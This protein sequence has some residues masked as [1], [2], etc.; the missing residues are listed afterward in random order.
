M[1]VTPKRIQNKNSS[2]YVKESKNIV[3]ES[4]DKKV[5]FKFI[6]AI[7]LVIKGEN[8]NTDFTSGIFAYFLSVCFNFLAVLG[9]ITIVAGS[10]VLFKEIFTI[11]WA[12]SNLIGNI[13]T[14]VTF[15]GILFICFLMS[16]ML[17]G[18]AN[19]IEKEKDR[20]FVIAVFSGVVSFV[21]LIIAL[22][23]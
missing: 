16:V 2:K 3:T 20:N 18:A 4:K 12:L 7:W 10:I 6:K 9:G 8:E 14:V 22:V 21:A 15:I 13:L 23:K 11:K 17:R 5:K 1:K 19:E